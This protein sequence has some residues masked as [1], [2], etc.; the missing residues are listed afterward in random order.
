MRPMSKR[1]GAILD[2]L[3]AGL[4][5]E[6]PRRRISNAP[7]RFLPIVIDKLGPRRFVV[8]RYFVR[9][10]ERFASPAL[11]FVRLDRGWFPTARTEPDGFV[12]AL[13]TSDGGVVESFYSGEYD[14]LRDVA[15]ALL[16]E[17]EAQ[18]G[19]LAPSAADPKGSQG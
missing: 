8:G 4:T 13:E 9:D 6:Y 10:G 16:V 17:I 19:D 18:Q 3:T 15:A 14:D 11:E 1:H 2:T 7:G 5:D 12:R